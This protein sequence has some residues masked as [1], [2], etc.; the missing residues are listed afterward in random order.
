LESFSVAN[1]NEVLFTDVWNDRDV[2][3]KVEVDG[4]RN[5]FIERK[6]VFGFNIRYVEDEDDRMFFRAVNEGGF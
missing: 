3:R 6:K 2:G 4:Q 5:E 1:S